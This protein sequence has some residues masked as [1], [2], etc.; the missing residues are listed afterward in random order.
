MVSSNRDNCDKSRL[1]YRVGF[2]TKNIQLKSK[3]IHLDSPDFGGWIR[4][5]PEITSRQNRDFVASSPSRNAKISIFVHFPVLFEPRVTQSFF[6]LHP[7]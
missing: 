5:G 7:F 6:P 3:L 4:G 1:Q 2:K